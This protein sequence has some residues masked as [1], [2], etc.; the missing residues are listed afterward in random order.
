MDFLLHI[1]LLCP[2]YDPIP[3]WLGTFGRI[4]RAGFER[5]SPSDPASFLQTVRKITLTRL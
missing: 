4:L 2:R 3:F 1:F 5:S